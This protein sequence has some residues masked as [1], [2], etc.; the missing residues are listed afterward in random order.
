MLDSMGQN[1]PSGYISHIAYQMH[2]PGVEDIN[3]NDACEDRMMTYGVIGIPDSKINGVDWSG[4]TYHITDSLLETYDSD[5]SHLDINLTYT[6]GWNTIDAQLIVNSDMD[7][8]DSVYLFLAVVEDSVYHTEGTTGQVNYYTVFRKFMHD[9]SDGMFLPNMSG[10]ITINVNSMFNLAPA[11]PYSENINEDLNNVT[12]VAFIQDVNSDEV[13]QSAVTEVVAAIPSPVG[14]V[15]ISVFP[16]VTRDKIHI[17]MNEPLNDHFYTV[18]SDNGQRLHQAPLQH[19]LETIDLSMY[20]SGNYWICVQ[21]KNTIS[22][23]Q[24]IVAD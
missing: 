13:L 24:V 20:A 15:D 19:T 16:T 22:T 21:G 11:V 23:V 3:F 12:L 4:Y 7:F 1:D 5:M 17:Q 10:P 2:W 18:I 8:T 9:D 6:A 14:T